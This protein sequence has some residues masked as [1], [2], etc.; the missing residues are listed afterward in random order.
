[1]YVSNEKL[2]PSPPKTTLPPSQRLV[3]AF[4][5]VGFRRASLPVLSPS[6]AVLVFYGAVKACLLYRLRVPPTSGSGSNIK[7][8]LVS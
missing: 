8:I 7:T 2:F 4:C 3:R 1:M 6:G 5:S